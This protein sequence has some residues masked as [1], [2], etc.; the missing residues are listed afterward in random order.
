MSK[1][2]AWDIGLK[3][4]SYCILQNTENIENTENTE[5]T[6]SGSTTK[7]KYTIVDWEVINLYPDE[8]KTVYTCDGITK[9]KE[10]CGKK[11]KY[12]NEKFNYCKT[13][14]NKFGLTLS[15]KKR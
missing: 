15:F 12:T 11:A 10:I 2:I 4:L 1:V 7:H 5:N 8:V 13:H 3:N 14:N 9:K 6:E